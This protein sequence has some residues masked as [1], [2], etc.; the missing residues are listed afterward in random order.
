MYQSTQMHF[1]VVLVFGMCIL[2]VYEYHKA[3]K[4]KI[5]LQSYLT[6]SHQVPPLTANTKQI[7]Y[8]KT[9]S[10]KVLLLRVYPKLVVA[11]PVTII[12]R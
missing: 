9:I 11:V 6:T 2:F 5:L 12:T 3:I 10:N 8:S 4:T 7:L 1:Q